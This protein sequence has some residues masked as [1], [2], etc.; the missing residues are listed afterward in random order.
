M[1]PSRH[2]LQHP[3]AAAYGMPLGTA[4]AQSPPSDTAGHLV[5]YNFGIP[6]LY[7]LAIDRFS[8]RYPNVTVEAL[9]IPSTEGWGGYQTNLALRMRSG[10]QTDIMA[11]AIEVAHEAIAQGNLAAAG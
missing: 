3:S 5:V 9:Y 1:Q 2:S 7:Q 8:E 6:E 10:Q 4:L 11:T